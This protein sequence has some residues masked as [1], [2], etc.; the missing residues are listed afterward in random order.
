METTRQA[1]VAAQRS[2]LTEH[3]IYQRLAKRMS[4]GENAKILRRIAA[5]EKRHH[6]FWEA[7][8]RR[9]VGANRFLVWGYVW[10]ARLFGITFSLKLMEKG[11]FFSQQ[12]Y[13]K[14]SDVEGIHRII[15]DEEEHERE[16]IDLLHDEPLEYAGS[17][18]LGLN[19]ALVELTG[20]LAGLTL[21]L[22]NGRVVAMAGLVTGIA[23]SLSMGASEYLSAKSEMDRDTVKSP[24][25]AALYTGTAYVFAV[26]LLILPFF[27]LAN[28]FVALATTLTVAVVIIA[29]FTFYIS[30]AKEVGFWPRFLEM[31]GI[32]LGVSA[33]SFGI[34][35]VVRRVMGVEI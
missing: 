8:T 13:A 10:L 4:D 5:D 31:A 34:G 32:S 28:V 25:K 9:R 23:A 6:D 1:M 16:L 3:I 17:I 11:E 27:L 30:V 15:H 29:T 33:I 7:L 22:A 18:V 2:E 24:A 26:V 14:M 20:A 35:F 19:D 12:Q 21:A